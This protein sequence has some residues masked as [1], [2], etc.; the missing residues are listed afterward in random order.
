MATRR[1]KAAA[2]IKPPPRRPNNDAQFDEV[3]DNLATAIRVI[4]Q[5]NAGALSF[6]E[7]YR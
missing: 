1:P 3:W 5:R 7:L 4:Y 6:E 2:K